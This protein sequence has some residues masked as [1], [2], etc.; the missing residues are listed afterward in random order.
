MGQK[1]FSE[2]PVTTYQST[3]H[4]IP[5]KRRSHFHCGGSLKSYTITTP[6][7]HVIMTVVGSFNFE[8]PIRL[9]VSTADMRRFTRRC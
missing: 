9:M 8:F 7:R 1:S 3:V 6:L 4:N 5:E 2:T